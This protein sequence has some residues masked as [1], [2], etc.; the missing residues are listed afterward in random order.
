MRWIGDA[1][2]APALRAFTGWTRLG[3]HPGFE[4][5]QLRRERAVFAGTLDAPGGP[6]RVV[7]KTMICTRLHLHLLHWVGP[8]RAARE[9]RHHTEARRLGLPVV[10]PLALGERFRFGAPVQSA[11]VTA[12]W[13]HDGTLESMA[14]DAATG[15]DVLSGLLH[16]LGGAVRRM[17]AAGIFHGDLHPGNVLVRRE[18]PDRLRIIDWKH[19]RRRRRARPEDVHAQLAKLVWQF[20]ESAVFRSD[21]PRLEARFFEGYDHDGIGGG[22]LRRAVAT[23][24]ARTGERLA[25]RA[26]RRCHGDNSTFARMR[27]GGLLL[28][29]R[30]EPGPGAI[31]EWARTVEGLHGIARGATARIP[32]AGGP[33]IRVERV[34]ETGRRPRRA[35]EEANRFH[36]LRGDPPIPLAWIEAEGTR[37]EG[38]LCWLEGADPTAPSRSR[39]GPG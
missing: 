24:V 38:W 17:H 12:Y 37:G 13:E 7:A 35:W 29:V 22:D 23:A 4:A 11:L 14:A 2:A 21:R 34:R 8:T 30:R 6:Q 18:D 3:E 33:S 32:V 25:E 16:A 36:A 9:W 10:R 26:A 19:V 15:A 31:P 39:S 27:E 28:W 20:R 5:L 1:A